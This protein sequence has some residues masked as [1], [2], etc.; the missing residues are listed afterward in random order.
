MGRT[1]KPTEATVNC[2][3]ARGAAKEVKEIKHFHFK[4]SS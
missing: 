4:K 3:N 1:A 2:V